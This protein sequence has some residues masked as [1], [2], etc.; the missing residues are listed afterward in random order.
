[1]DCCA[2]IFASKLHKM[3]Y[4]N[5][6]PA[7]RFEPALSY[8]SFIFNGGEPHIRIEPTTIPVDTPV[9]ITVQARTCN[10]FILAILAKDALRRMGFQ[11][12]ELYI[13]YMPAARQDRVMTSGEALSIKVYISIINAAGFSRVTV[14]DPH[15]E[16]TPAL[17]DQCNCVCNHQ[18]IQ[19]V[20]DTIPDPVQLTLIAPDAGSAKKIHHLAAALHWERVVQCDKIRDVRTGRLSGAQVFSDDLRGADCLIV[21]DI[22]DGG[23][24][25]LQLAKTLRAKNAGR[26]YLAISHGIFSNGT[27]AL[28]N[29]FDGVFTTN[30]FYDGTSGPKLKVLELPAP[31]ILTSSNLQILQ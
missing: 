14:F 4:L 10:D 31:Q 28:T 5:L 1:M 26:I 22:C 9:C 12:I 8:E 27:D 20:I 17:L 23:G 30:S 11:L 18:F 29:E 13:P 19:E 24:T 3:I 2:H 7:L 21:D 15:S 25:F 6:S 16:V